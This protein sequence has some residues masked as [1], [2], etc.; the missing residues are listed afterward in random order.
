MQGECYV[1]MKED[2]GGGTSICQRMPKIAS[3]PSEA[4]GETW[5]KFFLIL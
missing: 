2:I 3:N 5:N 1:K 4:M